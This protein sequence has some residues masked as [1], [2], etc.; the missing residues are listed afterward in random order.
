HLPWLDKVRPQLDDIDI[1]PLLAIQPR[2][3]YIPDLISP[4]PTHPRVTAAEQ[5]AEVRAT[6]LAVV[7]EEINRS[8]NERNGE[9]APDV[10]HEMARHPRKA[11]DRL[12]TAL[13][14]CWHRLVEPWWPRIANLL[15]ADITYHSRLLA[16]GGLARLF[17]AIDHR[18]SW[19][20]TTVRLST[21]AHPGVHGRDTGGLGLLLQPSAFGWPSLVAVWDE[22]YQPTIVYPARGVAEL[23]QPRVTDGDAA[24][25]RLIGRTRAALLASVVE[26]A[27]TSTLA[28]RHDLALATVSEHLSALAA[29][30]LATGSRTGRSVLY[31][32]T[33]L[34]EALLAG[35]PLK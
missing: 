18:I 19:T 20:G 5:L 25:A 32:I 26:P 24:L 6:P 29:A 4:M 23:W 34:G 10:L 15:S 13:D 1:A 12:A 21:G 27:T 11:R 7:K 9:P 14:E 31:S 17:P 35:E 3:G 28:R 16:D 30:G 22:R 33:A 2:R 8:L